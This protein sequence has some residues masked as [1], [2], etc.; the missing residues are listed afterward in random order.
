[1]PSGAEVLLEVLA[2]EGV[3]HVFG[4][5]GSTELP[6]LAA[7][8]RAGSADYV[9]GLQE[10]TV[11]A[12]ADG[13]AQATGR[14]A[15]VNLH[16]VA[17][18][19]NAAGSLANARANGAPLV[20]T[21]GNADSRHRVADPLLSGDLVGLAAPLCRWATEVRHAGEL[22]TLARRAFHDAAGPP[23]GPV[24]LSIPCD[25]LA[26]DAPGPAP[27]RTAARGPG[28]AAGLDDLARRLVAGPPGTLAIVAGDEVA[29]AG[30]CAAL[31]ALAERLGAP[32]YATPL[33][34]R[35]VFPTDHPLF[36]GPLPPRADAIRSALT[37]YR[38]VLLVGGQAFLVY[39]YTPGPPV[40]EGTELLHLSPDPAQLGRAHPAAFAASGDLAASLDALLA[41][42]A[43]AGAPPS[44]AAVPPAAAA[45]AAGR[46]R[47]EE[48]ARARSGE[49]PMHPLAAVHALVR[50]LP[51]E[52]VV[53]DE[54]ITAGAYVRGLHR[55]AG[56]H[57]YWFCRGGGLGWGMPAAC[58][59]SLAFGGEPVLCVVGDGSAMY[60]PQALWSAANRNLPVVFAVVD[61]GQ[62]L[63][64]KRNQGSGP[65]AGMDLA[66]P[67]LDFC[68]LA[69]SMGVPATTVEKAP[70]VGEALRAVWGAGP[71]LLHLPV[72]ATPA[73]A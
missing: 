27:P 65:Y 7:L 54:A 45:H 44:A 3:R 46:R 21:A 63:I 31:V 24:F 11:V 20:V 26:E 70:D 34:G 48:A 43:G 10:A 12:M 9:L 38:R 28:P 29:A 36:A 40:P 25:V 42:V 53:V 1:V 66:P 57:T 13:Y 4:N 72:S 61:N 17:G 5:P 50:A 6:F 39:P 71:H 35:R 52:S 8:A 51:P 47:H 15:F 16:S 64:L 55:S 14:P 22:G 59:I 41:L 60:S 18:L 32:V 73:G 37:P 58:G 49:V 33:H 23:P 30:A 67:A 56:P 19:G 69:R 2:S 68:H 62:Y